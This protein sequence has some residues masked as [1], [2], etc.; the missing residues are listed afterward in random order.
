M[1]T[2]TTIRKKGE[3]PDGTEERRQWLEMEKIRSAVEYCTHTSQLTTRHMQTNKVIHQHTHAL[4][5]HSL[6][7]THTEFKIFVHFLFHIHWIIYITE[8]VKAIYETIARNA[9][10]FNNGPGMGAWGI[11]EFQCAKDANS[12]TWR[13]LFSICKKK[14]KI[15]I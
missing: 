12:S 6:T 3:K 10:L 14:K 9:S 8:T 15:Y 7:H 13:D 5:P 11:C 2:N 4:C 1:W